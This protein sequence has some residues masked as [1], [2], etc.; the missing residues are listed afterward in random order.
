MIFL[1]I[2]IYIYIYIYTYI[3]MYIYRERGCPG[4][5]HGGDAAAQALALL[6]PEPEVVQRS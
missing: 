1:N 6:A 3:Y 4:R 2:Y 5:D